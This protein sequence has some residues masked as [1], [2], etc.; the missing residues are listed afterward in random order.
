M[1]KI[2]AALLRLERS[3]EFA[4]CKLNEIQFEAPWNPTGPRCG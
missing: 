1:R 3:F 2:I 4:L